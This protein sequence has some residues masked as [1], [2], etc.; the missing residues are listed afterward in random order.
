MEVP[1]PE[2]TEREDNKPSPPRSIEFLTGC[3]TFR[4]HSYKLSFAEQKDRRL[5]GKKRVRTT[6]AA[7]LRSL[8]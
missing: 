4:D 7:A 3:V 5:C 6:F 8:L 2:A 1:S